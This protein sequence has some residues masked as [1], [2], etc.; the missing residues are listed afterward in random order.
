MYFTTADKPKLFQSPPSVRKATAPTE[1]LPMARTFQSPPSVR[2][3]TVDFLERDKHKGISI[4]A[5]REE[6]DL[7]TAIVCYHK[8]HFNPRLP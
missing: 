5:F 8:V 4:P 2:K 7:F 6:G 1:N 3:A